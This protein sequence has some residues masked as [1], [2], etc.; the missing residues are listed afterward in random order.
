MMLLLATLPSVLSCFGPRKNPDPDFK[1]QIDSFADLKVMRY[2]VPGWENL[3]LQQKA[4]AHLFKM[5][6]GAK[7]AGLET[8]QAGS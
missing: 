6:S 8:F 7:E 1:Y 4:Y 2:K 3:S 5:I